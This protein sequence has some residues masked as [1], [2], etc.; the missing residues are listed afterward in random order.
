MISYR[1]SGDECE[2]G[3]LRREPGH[4]R[5]PQAGAGLLLRT[6]SPRAQTGLTYQVLQR[7]RPGPPAQQGSRAFVKH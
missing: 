5:G 1:K 3:A 6:S 2:Q 7:I 4:V